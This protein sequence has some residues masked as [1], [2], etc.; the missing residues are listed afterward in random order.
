MS[1]TGDY[2]TDTINT[3]LYG[4][5]RPVEKYGEG[6]IIRSKD[7]KKRYEVYPGGYDPRRDCNLYTLTDLATKEAIYEVGESVLDQYEVESRGK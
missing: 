6:D 5:N 7:G 4:R 2:W 3:R 1:W